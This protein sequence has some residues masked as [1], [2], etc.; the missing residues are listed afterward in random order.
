MQSI[1]NSNICFLTIFKV[2]NKVIYHTGIAKTSVTRKTLEYR[3][4]NL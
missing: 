2:Q 1:R 4:I 3:L